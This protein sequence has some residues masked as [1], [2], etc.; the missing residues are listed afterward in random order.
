M[1]EEKK[2]A[3]SILQSLDTSVIDS[4]NALIKALSTQMQPFIN[5]DTALLYLLAGSK[6]TAHSHDF[7]TAVSVRILLSSTF[8]IGALST[9]RSWIPGA[10]PIIVQQMRWI[11]NLE[12]LL[13]GITY[14]AIQSPIV[15]RA[16]YPP[17]DKTSAHALYKFLIGVYTAINQVP[18]ISMVYPNRWQGSEVG[19]E[20]GNDLDDS[21]G[22][23][24]EVHIPKNVAKRQH[25]QQTRS[26]VTTFSGLC[27]EKGIPFAGETSG[28]AAST[29][30]F[31]HQQLLPDLAGDGDDL[32]KLCMVLLGFPMLFSGF[33]SLLETYTGLAYA[34]AQRANKKS[35]LLT[36]SLIRRRSC[37]Y[38]LV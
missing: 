1:R 33:H 36:L 23:R 13:S 34:Q 17:T 18:Y 8:P 35:A 19:I 16:V 4:L 26:G 10:S 11:S 31:I 5:D 6:R 30:L 25:Y 14:Q 15:D 9:I 28:S 2:L 24:E 32:T 29:V 20:P 38:S 12:T 7:E 3:Y 22:T 27:Q 21:R 37:R